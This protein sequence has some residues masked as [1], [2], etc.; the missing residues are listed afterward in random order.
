MSGRSSETKKP[1]AVA[2][3]KEW[4][5]ATMIL[6]TSALIDYILI[7]ASQFQVKLARQTYDLRPL[8]LPLVTRI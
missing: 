5:Q 2:I 7:Q 3:S 4:F 6:V 1:R 8:M